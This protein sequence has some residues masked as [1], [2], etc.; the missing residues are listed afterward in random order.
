MF[1][2][3]VLFE[4]IPT[5]EKKLKVELQHQIYGVSIYVKCRGDYIVVGDMMFSL[6]LLHYIKGEQGSRFE[7]VNEN[8]FFLMESF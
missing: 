2:Q 4:W 7:K 8:K 1:I 5:D 6:T 3:L